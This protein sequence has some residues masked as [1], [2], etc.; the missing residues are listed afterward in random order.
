MNNRTKILSTLSSFNTL[1]NDFPSLLSID[2][3][4]GDENTSVTVSFLLDLGNLFGLTEKKLLDWISKILTDDENNPKKKGLLSVIE[5]SVKAALLLH[6]NSLYDCEIAPILPDEFLKYSYTS[7][8]HPEIED[9]KGAVVRL[10]SIDMFNQLRFYPLGETGQMFYF[11]IS[12]NSVNRQERLYRSCDFDAWLWWI[13]NFTNEVNSKYYPWDNRCYY[14]TDFVGEDGDNNRIN[15]IESHINDSPFFNVPRVGHKK[16]IISA[17]YNE[18]GT[19]FEN[20]NTLTV[21]GCS[22]TYKN[23]GILGQNKTIFEFN[24]DYI[25]SLKLF[26]SKTL[27]AQ[28][29]N[30][31]TGLS[32]AMFGIL[33]LDLNILVKKVEKTVDIVISKPISKETRGYFEFS[34]DEY[35]DIVNDATLRYNGEYQTSNVNRDVVKLDVTEIT[36]AIK[37]I[38]EAGTSTEKEEAISYSIKALGDS[39]TE[40][41]VGVNTPFTQQ[42][43]ILM[44]FLREI[45]TQISLQVLSPKVMLLFAINDYFLNEEG[46]SAKINIEGFMKDFWNIISSCVLKISDLILESLYD[47]IIGFIRPI[48]VLVVEKLLLETLMYYKELLI[49]L[50]TNC[51]PMISFRGNT[52]NFVIDN[53]NYADIIPSQTT[54]S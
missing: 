6:F 4:G 31:I 28:I 13:I 8:P 1:L 48:L 7:K 15:F 22:E 23:T 10:Q 17:Y 38:D 24:Y 3:N 39:I 19:T 35:N 52:T 34:E 11:D 33:S 45:I 42:K 30:A 36:N 25:Y 9:G 51:L 5:E 47:M 50:L 54:P 16:H 29:I 12:K 18:K 26:D 27:V 40:Y 43:D 20:S 41:S 53:V 37:K 21:F 2:S 14:R 32:G 49:N 44:R 46:N